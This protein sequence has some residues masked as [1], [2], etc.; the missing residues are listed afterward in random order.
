MAVGIILNIKEF[1]V[2]NLVKCRKSS[3]AG[4]YKIIKVD[5]E[6]LQVML[7]GARRGEW[8]TIM[9]IRPIR[10][11]EEWLKELGVYALNEDQA[12]FGDV[13]EDEFGFFYVTGCENIGGDDTGSRFLRIKKKIKYVHQLQNL[14]F[15]L[16]DKEIGD[17]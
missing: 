16:T 15:H 7:D 5:Y 12:Y 6:N 11:T 13:F 17:E 1:S 4:I 9:N 14:H 3:D 10:L 8:H 2:G